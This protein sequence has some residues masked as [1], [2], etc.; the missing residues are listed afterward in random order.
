MR[1]TVAR[2]GAS[3]QGRIQIEGRVAAEAV[4]GIGETALARAAGT[5]EG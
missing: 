1:G 2:H 3:A 4:D 5:C